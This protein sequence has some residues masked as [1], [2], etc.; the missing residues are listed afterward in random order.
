MQIAHILLK[1]HGAP[2]SCFCGPQPQKNVFERVHAI[3]RSGDY[4]SSGSGRAADGKKK[5]PRRVLGLAVVIHNCNYLI[6]CSAI[7][8]TG[9]AQSIF[10][11]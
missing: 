3:S 11:E 2:R 4:P 8:R 10:A 7:L 9:A 5:A 1:K 6:I